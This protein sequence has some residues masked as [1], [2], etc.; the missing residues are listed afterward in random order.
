MNARLPLIRANIRKV[1]NSVEYRK[2]RAEFFQAHPICA[3]CDSLGLT[4]PGEELDH[5]VPAF[6]RPDLFWEQSNW[7]MLCCECHKIKSDAEAPNNLVRT[8]AEGDN[9]ELV[10]G[11]WVLVER[12]PMKKSD[13]PRNP[14]SAAL[15]KRRERRARR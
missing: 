9:E 4:G 8:N 14:H 2:R 13:T 1:R 10:N 6:K 3:R 7:Q 5:I 15:Q 11:R 12:A